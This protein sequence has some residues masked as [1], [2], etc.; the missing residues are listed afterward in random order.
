M[1]SVAGVAGVCAILGLINHV[2]G[3]ETVVA[4]LLEKGSVL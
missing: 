1:K 3:A 4:N 2:S